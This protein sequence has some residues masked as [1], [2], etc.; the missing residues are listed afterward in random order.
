[1]NLIIRPNQYLLLVMAAV[2]F[3]ASL[4]HQ[5]YMYEN[6][7][8]GSRDLSFF[9]QSLWNAMH[10]EGLRTTIGWLGEHLFSEHFYLGHYLLVPFYYIWPS[11][12]LLF[13]VQALAVSVAGIAL[14]KIA[15]QLGTSNKE[16]L[17]LGVLFL[18]QPS[19]HGAAA[20]MNFYGYHP[21]V[22]F[23]P[24]FLFCYLAF[25]DKRWLLFWVL[26]F[27][28]LT[29]TEQSSLIFAPL[30]AYWF[31]KIGRIFSLALVLGSTAWFLF[32]TKFGMPFVA[33][34]DGPYYFS[35][36][37]SELDF[38][39][40]VNT[41]QKLGDYTIK[42]LLLFGGLPLLSLFSLVSIPVILIFAQAFYS[43]YTMPL[44]MLSWHTA[45]WLPV[46]GIS[47]IYGYLT[48]QKKLP[49]KLGQSVLPYGVLILSLLAM[50]TTFYKIYAIPI[51]SLSEEVTTE[52]NRLKSEVPVDASVSATF[53]I[54]AHFSHRKDLYIFPNIENADFVLINENQSGAFVVDSKESNEAMEINSDYHLISS[55]AGLMLYQ[56]N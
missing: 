6:L 43:G 4:W 53:F 21:D 40:I 7:A 54:G 37:T 52:L 46:L 22:L 38:E 26:V 41:A 32:A 19:L 29:N 28:C 55:N 35:A 27:A 18:S 3:F 8:M 16:A 9:T 25:L 5:S 39:Q 48:L 49:P 34:V 15:L 12:H 13:A 45:Y 42:L 17:L 24:L 36:A 23:V 30:G 10:G 31:F 1:M 44:A 47:M 2:C 11:P 56:H 51:P 20:G 14:Y 33:G 50:T